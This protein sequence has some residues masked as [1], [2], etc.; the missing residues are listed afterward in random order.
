MFLSIRAQYHERLNLHPPPFIDLEMNVK[1]GR[2][3]L[4]EFKYF[5]NNSTKFGVI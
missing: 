2:V 1:I 5:S 4:K 3:T